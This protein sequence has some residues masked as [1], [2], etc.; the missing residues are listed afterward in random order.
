MYIYLMAGKWLIKILVLSLWISGVLKVFPGCTSNRYFGTPNYFTGQPGWLYLK[1]GIKIKGKISVNNLM[2]NSVEVRTSK[3]E[4]IKYTIGEVMA[5]Y[6]D[7]GVFEPK[8][9]RTQVL[10]LSSRLEFMERLTPDSSTIHLYEAYEKLTDEKLMGD[11]S[12]Y[13]S[14]EYDLKYYIHLPGDKPEEVWE[15]S[16]GL[17]SEHLS[18]GLETLFSDCPGLLEKIRSGDPAYNI[19]FKPQIQLDHVTVGRLTTRDKE[20][21]VKVILKVLAEYEQCVMGK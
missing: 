16:I 20:A 2:G 1:N 18:K 12:L 4:S 11:V 14:V 10:N 9:I 5:C 8:I 21:K 13:P 3:K 7:I 15:L 17:L 19:Y 6:L